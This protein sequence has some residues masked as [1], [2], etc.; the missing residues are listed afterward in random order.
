MIKKLIK[1][2]DEIMDSLKKLSYILNRPQTSLINEAIKEYIVER[3]EGTRVKSKYM[4]PSV[5]IKSNDAY[6]NEIDK[7]RYP[8]FNENK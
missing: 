8:R 2:D 7:T 6:G 5:I 4:K 3:F 1:I